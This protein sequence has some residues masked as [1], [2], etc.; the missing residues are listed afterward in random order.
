MNGNIW[1]IPVYKN[2]AKYNVNN[3]RPISVI[4]IVVKIMEKVV[5]MA[6]SIPIFEIITFSQTVSMALEQNIQ[7]FLLYLKLQI[8]GITTLTL[9]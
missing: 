3:Y 5:H 1:V 7:L 6:N 2:G 8:N 4:S 9:T